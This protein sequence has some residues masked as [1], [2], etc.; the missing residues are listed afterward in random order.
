[1]TE[2]TKN[3]RKTRGAL[4]AYTELIQAT[5]KMNALLDRQLE[6]FELTTNQFRV[7]EEV[8]RHGSLS[9]TGLGER[10]ICTGGNIT[11]L[12]GHLERRGLTILEADARDARKRMVRLTAEGEKLMAK[13]YP[14]RAKVV[15]AQMSTLGNREQE[16]L[17]RLCRKL[18]E[19]DAVKFVNEMTRWDAEEME[20][21]V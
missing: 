4:D 2:N 8:K 21:G 13:I 9:F 14:L 12:A 10:L 11:H 7:L 19:G 3:N 6:S 17:R 20:A 1:M 16:T 18:V 15:R 5:D